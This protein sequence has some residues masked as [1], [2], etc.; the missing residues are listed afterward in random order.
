MDTQENNVIVDETFT[1]A[2]DQTPKSNT[3]AFTE[4]KPGTNWCNGTCGNYWFEAKLFD[5]GSMF[6]INDG[7]VSKLHIRDGNGK[8]VVNYD[9]GWDIRPKTGDIKEA[10]NAILAFLEVAP[11]RFE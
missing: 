10:Y 9:R 11:K 5:T 4:F 2:P 1:F 6:G 7:R 8:D 3:V